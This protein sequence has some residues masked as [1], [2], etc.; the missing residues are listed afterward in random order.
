MPLRDLMQRYSIRKASDS[1]A[2]DK[3]SCQSRH[4]SFLLQLDWGLIAGAA[5]PAVGARTFPTD[6]LP[7]SKEM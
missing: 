5:I 6:P 4:C 3:S 7:R 2:E 1:H